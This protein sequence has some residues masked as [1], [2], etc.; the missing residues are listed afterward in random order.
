MGVEI[1]ERPEFAELYGKDLGTYERIGQAA[2][3]Q[4]REQ[5][6]LEYLKES[7]W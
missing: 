7:A 2:Q 6:R 4:Q 5:D 3:I 1:E